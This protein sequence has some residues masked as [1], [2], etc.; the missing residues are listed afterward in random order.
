MS[1][2][3]LTRAALLLALTLLFQS[4]RFFIPLPA[5]FST[6]LIG[7][8][9]NTCLFLALLTAGFWPACLIAVIT[10]IV[11]YM[12]SLLPLPIFVLPVAIGNLLYVIF[13]KMLTVNWHTWL[14]ITAASLG[15]MVWLYFSFMFL[16]SLLALPSKMAAVLLLAMSWPQF[17][18]GCIG[19][20][21]AIM[22]KKRIKV[23]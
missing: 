2:Q 3:L 12:Q 4:L 19:G 21:L 13:L 23:G 17:V 18:T 5:A 10:P 9:V 1:V 15:K 7:S 20:G 6:L 8:L 14:A 16:L 11:A 22:V